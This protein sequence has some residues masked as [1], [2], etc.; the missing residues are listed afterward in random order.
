MGTGSMEPR[1]LLSLLSSL[2]CCV[3]P[4]SLTLSSSPALSSLLSRLTL[5]ST[6]GTR[7][8]STSPPQ[9]LR[10]PGVSSEHPSAPQR[11]PALALPH[12]PVLAARRRGQEGTGTDTSPEQRPHPL[13]PRDIGAGMRQAMG[14][15]PLLPWQGDRDSVEVTVGMGVAA[16]GWYLPSPRGAMGN[17][18]PVPA[19]SPA[20]TVLA[21]DRDWLLLG[22]PLASSLLLSSPLSLSFHGSPSSSTN[23]GDPPPSSCPPRANMD[24]QIPSIRMHAH[25][26]WHH[27][28]VAVL[29]WEW[30]WT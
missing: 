8:A 10:A 29:C 7:P 14:T 15:S 13:P 30:I 28:A 25:R 16:C 4:G 5:R 19:R 3:L 23:G 22:K 20:L 21:Q 24:L 27:K 18:P 26:D 2:L 17:G 1:E 9:V 6:P 12:L 11:E